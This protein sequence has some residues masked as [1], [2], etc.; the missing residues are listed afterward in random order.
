M[1]VKTYEHLGREADLAIRNTAR[2]KQAVIDMGSAEALGTRI[3]VTIEGASWDNGLLHLQPVLQDIVRA[4][5]QAFVVQ[6][7]QQMQADTKA[8]TDA[9]R[10]RFEEGGDSYLDEGRQVPRAAGFTDPVQVAEHDASTRETPAAP[11]AG[12][13]SPSGPSGGMLGT[14]EGAG[15]VPLGHSVTTPGP[16]ATKPAPAVEMKKQT[17]ELLEW[18]Y[19]NP[20]STVAVNADLQELKSL[21]MVSQQGQGPKAT[22]SA[23]TAGAVFLGHQG[24]PVA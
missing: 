16:V 2:A 21:K 3:I 5:T 23:T 13:M 22:Y 12:T 19:A 11:G 14:G 10:L 8:R 7:V 17:R 20:G 15:Q 1:S 9:L 4:N 24:E 6:A 18:I